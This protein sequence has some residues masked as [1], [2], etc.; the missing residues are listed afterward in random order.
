MLLIWNLD[1]ILLNI[2]QDPHMIALA[3]PYFHAMV[4]AIFP[5]L[6]FTVFLHFVM[7]LG[8]MRTNLVFTLLWVPLNIFLNYCL[9]FGKFG[10]PA[11]GIA[12][13]GYGMA[14][15]F[16]IIAS[17]MAVYLLLSKTYRIYFQHIFHNA[18]PSALMELLRVGLP[19]GLMFCIEIGFF[20]CITLIMGTLSSHAVA[21]NQITMQFL[22]QFSTVSFCFAQ[23]ITVRMGHC[24]GAQDILVAKRAAYIGMFMAFSFMCVVAVIYWLFAEQLVHLDLD[25]MIASNS[26]AIAMAKQLLAICAFVQIFESVRLTA[27]GALRALKDTR[28][29]LLISI[30]TFWLIAIP[31][32]YWFAMKLQWEGNGLWWGMVISQFIG[33]V[34]LVWRYQKRMRDVVKYEIKHAF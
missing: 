27:F 6:M 32:G 14:I 12:G 17:I 21:A 16:W 23:A 29:T 4:W 22:G 26:K 24:L 25:P 5:D 11:L 8:H 13:A 15:S 18:I 7:G 31:L 2:G 33:A 28:F 30:L 9:I 19:M 3:K 1:V 34:I 20:T 10:L